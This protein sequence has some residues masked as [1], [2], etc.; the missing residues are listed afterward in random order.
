MTSVWAQEGSWPLN[1]KRMTWQVKIPKPAPPTALDGDWVGLG[2]RGT[3]F[4]ISFSVS[5]P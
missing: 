1:F 4:Q 2:R 5:H 3:H